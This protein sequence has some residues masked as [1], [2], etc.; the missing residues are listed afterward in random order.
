MVKDS[1]CGY[2]NEESRGRI[3]ER[4]LVSQSTRQ[5]VDMQLVM[6]PV[7]QLDMQE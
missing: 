2:Q 1:A 3:S 5:Q 7:Q 4:S 6:L